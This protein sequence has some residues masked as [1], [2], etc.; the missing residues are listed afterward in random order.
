MVIRAV[1]ERWNGRMRRID[2]RHCW[3]CASR[4]SEVAPRGFKHTAMQSLFGIIGL[5][6]ITF[7]AIQFHLQQVPP[8]A[9]IGPGTISFLYLIVIAYVS[10]RAGF[11]SAVAV[12]LIAVFCMNYFVLPLVPSLAAKNPL[13]ILASVVFLMTAWII[14]GI[15]ARL[16]EKCALLDALFEQAPAA[17]ALVNVK[18]RV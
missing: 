9:F 14:T 4:M 18:A 11:V 15:V 7:A 12:S 17:I 3:P 8:T 16:R 10:L 1:G 2:E 6:L 5:S 13:D